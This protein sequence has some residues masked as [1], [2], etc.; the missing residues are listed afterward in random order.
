MESGKEEGGKWVGV[1]KTGELVRRLLGPSPG[2]PRPGPPSGTE[3]AVDTTETPNTEPRRVTSPFPTLPRPSTVRSPDSPVV[4]Q[5]VVTLGESFEKEPGFLVDYRSERLIRKQVFPVQ[6]GTTLPIDPDSPRQSPHTYRWDEGWDSEEKKGDGRR[7]EP[8]PSERRFRVVVASPVRS[9]SVALGLTHS[10]ASPR[11]RRFPRASNTLV[12]LTLTSTPTGDGRDWGTDREQVSVCDL[13][14]RLQAATRPGQGRSPGSSTLAPPALTLAV[15]ERQPPPARPGPTPSGPCVGVHSSLGVVERREWGRPRGVSYGRGHERGVRP[16]P[17][18]P[19][20]RTGHCGAGGR[21]TRSGN[22]KTNKKDNFCFSV[23]KLF[24][25]AHPESRNGEDEEMRRS[26]GVG[27]PK[28]ESRS[29][30]EGDVPHHHRRVGTGYT[31]RGVKGRKTDRK[32]RN[33]GPGRVPP[34][35]PG[36]S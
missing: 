25:T 23:C 33:L 3:L 6:T 21:E 27:T 18:V 17:R 22:T 12:V 28:V 26:P 36:L 4:P 20:P 2:P 31:G 29:S 24:H 1:S 15:P 10:C 16:S 19:R 34:V 35:P 14:T 7:R 11:V 13:D 30:D 9:L 5:S 8:T 32:R